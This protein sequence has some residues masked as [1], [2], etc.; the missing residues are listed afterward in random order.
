MKIN[1]ADIIKR[2]STERVLT[3][4][5]RGNGERLDAAPDLD[6]LRTLPDFQ[7]LRLDLN[8]PADPFAG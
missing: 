5:Q 7:M 4:A 6:R 1:P 3:Q 2:S 8:F